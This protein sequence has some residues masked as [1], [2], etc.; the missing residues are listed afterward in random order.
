MQ[1]TTEEINYLKDLYENKGLSKSE[2]CPMFIQYNRT[3]DSIWVKIKRLKLTHTKEQTQKIKSRVNCGERNGMF[4]K[5]S[6]LKGLRK[7][8]SEIIKLRSEKLSET[9]KK[10]YI[11]GELPILLGKKNPMFGKLPWNI[12][13]T[14]ETNN[15][16]RIAGEKTSILRKNEWK[17]K[18]TEDKEKIIKRLNLAMIQTKK[19]TKIEN[20]VNEFLKSLNIKFEKNYPLNGFYVDFYIFDKNLVI[21]CDGDYWHANPMFFN[22]DYLTLPQI[23]TIDRDK[24]KNEMLIINNINYIRFWEYEIKKHF[25][26]VK[27]KILINIT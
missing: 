14:K 22:N 3:C 1:W 2:I 24:R 11:N 17:N 12:G 16:L 15:S 7:E 23:K 4:G 25:E 20:K 13:L 19:P 26:T 21:E 27:E 5:D 9:R 8:N 10:M 6:P 18:T